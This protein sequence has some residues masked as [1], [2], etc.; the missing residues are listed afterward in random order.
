[1]HWNFILLLFLVGVSGGKAFGQSPT[2][3]PAPATR[4]TETADQAQVLRALLEEVRLLRLALERS[5]ATLPAFQVLLDRARFQHEIVTQR[6]QQINDARL[7]M[8]R[9]RLEAEQSLR[10]VEELK[11]RQSQSADPEMQTLNEREIKELQLQAEQQKEREELYRQQWNR[12]TAQ[13]AE[14][15]AKLDELNTRLNKLQT[16]LTSTSTQTK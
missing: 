11:K 2:S 1:M 5:Q 10:R 7:E 15:Q 4:N 8:E 16:T 13:L 14:E 9:S 12:L 3:L 6:D